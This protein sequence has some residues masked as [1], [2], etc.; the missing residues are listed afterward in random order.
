MADFDDKR[1]KILKQFPKKKVLAAV[2]QEFMLDP[3][4][5]FFNTVSGSHAPSCF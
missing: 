3:Q 1:K 2:R 4:M 5:T